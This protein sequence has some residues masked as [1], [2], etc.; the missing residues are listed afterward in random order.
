MA[1]SAA[2]CVMGGVGRM[3]ANRIIQSPVLTFCDP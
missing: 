3:V 2:L 1:V